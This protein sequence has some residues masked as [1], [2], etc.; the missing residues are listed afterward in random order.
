MAILLERLGD[1][2]LRTRVSVMQILAALGPWAEMDPPKEVV[3]ALRDESVD[4]RAMAVVTLGGFDR[5]LEPLIPSLFQVIESDVPGVGTA[6]A[7]LLERL[8]PPSNLTKSVVPQLIELLH[9]PDE[10]VRSVACSMLEKLGPD[11]R[12]AIPSL[13]A[14]ARERHS[15]S[16]RPELANS[17][18]DIRAIEALRRIA[19][20]S[21]AAS[22]VV[23]ALTEL[24]LAK[25]TDKWRAAVDALVGFGPDAASAVPELIRAVCRR[26]S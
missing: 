2:D 3:A 1:K 9:R 8:S 4:I 12:A 11:A 16:A 22:Q 24:I 17:S 19:P 18:P 15:V 10:R 25:E 20:K 23:A 6:C 26:A 13:I 7:A 5:G 21:E 14:T